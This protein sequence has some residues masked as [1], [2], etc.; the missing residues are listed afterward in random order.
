MQN[1]SHKI[2]AHS[3]ANKSKMNVEEEDARDLGAV[4]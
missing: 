2:L 1:V 3:T 4:A